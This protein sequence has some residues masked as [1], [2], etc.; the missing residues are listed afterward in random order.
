MFYAVV[1]IRG[2]QHIKEVDDPVLRTAGILAILFMLM[3][4]AY[5]KFDMQFVNPR[6]MAFLGC[7]AGL[8]SVLPKIYRPDDTSRLLTRS[9]RT[10]NEALVVSDDW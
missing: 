6:Q 5:G 3:M 2:S 10:K 1:L 7:M 9:K 8:L 4:F